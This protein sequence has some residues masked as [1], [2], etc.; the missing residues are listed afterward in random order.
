MLNPETTEAQVELNFNYTAGPVSTTVSLDFGNLSVYGNDDNLE[1]AYITYDFGNGFSVTSGR[2]LTYM[3]YEAFDPT[4]MYQ[5][6]YA[7]DVEGVQDIYDAYDYGAS[8][9]LRNRYVQRWSLVKFG[10]GLG[11]EKALPWLLL[12]SK[13][14]LP[15]QFGLILAH[16]Q[17]K[18][19]KNLPTGSSIKWT[20]YFSLQKLQRQINLTLVQMLTE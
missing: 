2:M 12:V 20:S 17:L 6:S 5:F 19:M 16:Q 4:N 14:S 15:R 9:D 10:S 8:N 18:R 3:G 11:Y 13:T 1:E 7:Y